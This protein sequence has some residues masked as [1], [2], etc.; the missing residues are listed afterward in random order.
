[1]LFQTSG[2]GERVGVAHSYVTE[3]GSDLRDNTG[4]PLRYKT[5]RSS[6][7][8]PGFDSALNGP[9]RKSISSGWLVIMRAK[10]CYNCRHEVTK[11]VIALNKK[12]LGRRTQR[13][14]C[15]KCLAEYLDCTEDD[16]RSKIREFIEQGCA[17]FV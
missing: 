9:N 7:M 11:D 6:R 13:V 3:S 1:M 14:L 12:L 5:Q 2:S 4:A 17:L 8:V 10:P 15:L 16:L